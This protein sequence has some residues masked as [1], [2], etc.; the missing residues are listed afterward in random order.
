[1]A[2]PF[3]DAQNLQLSGC[4]EHHAQDDLAFNVKPPSFF[5]VNGVRFGSNLHRL[6]RSSGRLR[7]RL[8]RGLRQRSCVGETAR[9][10]LSL[11]GR[12]LTGADGVAEAGARHYPPRAVLCAGPIPRPWANGLI[13]GS[14]VRHI[15]MA[16]AL[17]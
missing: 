7:L 11:A 6:E 15:A 10:D 4:L 13:K 5:R 16:S 12:S 14:Y 8:R 17:G 1:M 3:A 9:V 2:K